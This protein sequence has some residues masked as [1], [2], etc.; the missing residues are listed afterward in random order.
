MPQ[1]DRHQYYRDEGPLPELKLGDVAR[2]TALIFGAGLAL[3]FWDCVLAPGYF[4][5][6][7]A[8]DAAARALNPAHELAYRG[9]FPAV[10]APY[11]P[12]FA[13]I[14][15]A[16]AAYAVFCVC[17]LFARFLSGWRSA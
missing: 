12:F 16:L 4:V 5:L 6:V 11:A 9:P 3:W 13:A 15:F 2:N 14:L 7:Y 1:H 10:V 17:R 8:Y